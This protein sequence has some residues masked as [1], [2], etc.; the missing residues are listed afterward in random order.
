MAT[1]NLG[2]VSGLS[3]YEVWLNQG[4][5]G[6]EQDYIDSLN[7]KDGEDGISPTATVT[8]TENGATI[9]ITDVNGTTTANIYHGSLVTLTQTEYDALVT[10]GTVDNNTYYFIIEEEEE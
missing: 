2:R 7:G 8:A 4:N 1:K 3:A 6:T 9:T 5:E 10:A